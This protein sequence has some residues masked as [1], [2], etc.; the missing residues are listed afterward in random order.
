MSSKEVVPLLSLVLLDLL[1]G[2]L[3]LMVLMEGVATAA[4]RGCGCDFL[5]YLVPLS[6]LWVF[7]YLVPLVLDLKKKKD[8]NYL[9]FIIIIH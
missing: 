8:N 1:L 4:N 5:L 6:M 2:L 3:F 9:L 7:L